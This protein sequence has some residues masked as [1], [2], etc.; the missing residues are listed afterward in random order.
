MKLA[1]IVDD[2][3]AI[4]D[5]LSAVLRREGWIAESAIDGDDAIAMLKV[6][7][8][9][10]I[11]LDLLM[12]RIDGT[13]V[14]EFMKQ[15]DIATPVIVVAAAPDEKVLDPRIVRMVLKKPIEIGDLR[16]ILQAIKGT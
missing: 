2:D 9:S 1:L 6:K 13:G 5:I 3:P 16:T 12:P 11:V 7:T 15:Q 8:Y 10:I 14:L 4:R